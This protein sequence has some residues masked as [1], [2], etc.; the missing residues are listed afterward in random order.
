MNHNQRLDIKS[1]LFL[2]L[3]FA[4]LMFFI[5]GWVWTKVP[6]GQKIPVHWN[7]EGKVDRLGGKF[8]GLLLMPL[9]C[10]GT[11]L[12]FTFLPSLEPRRLNLLRS[13][14]VYKIFWIAIILFLFVI[15]VF[16]VG[17]ALGK[18]PDIG[19]IVPIMVGILFIVL[20]NYMGKIRSNWF[21]GIRTPWTL[22]SDLSWKKT[23]RIGGILFVLTGILLLIL[24]IAGS[25]KV[26]I[27]GM[28]VIMGGVIIYLFVY[29]YIVWR[30]DPNKHSTGRG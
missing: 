6:E 25:G 4:S 13:L 28:I 3:V 20:G 30:S 29:S 11:I 23:H 26:F 12:L 9:V 1:P 17:G 5:S 2:S 19:H 22:S 27:T 21:M 24:A 15:H 8:E 7:I 10:L 16:L 18:K 14:K